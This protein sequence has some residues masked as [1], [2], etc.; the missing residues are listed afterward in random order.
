MNLGDVYE[1]GCFTDRARTPLEDSHSPIS[2]NSKKHHPFVQPI[3]VPSC[4]E[5][6]PTVQCLYLNFLQ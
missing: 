5:N 2:S 6:E 3:Y 4:F 1:A